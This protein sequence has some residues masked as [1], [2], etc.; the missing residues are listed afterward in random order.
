MKFFR[1]T[2]VAMLIA[3]A[4]ASTAIQPASAFYFGEDLSALES[5]HGVAIVYPKSMGPEAP[6]ASEVAAQTTTEQSAAAEQL[7]TV[8]AT[9][10]TAEVS[11]TTTTTAAPEVTTV[12][13]SPAAATTE[14]TVPVAAASAPD[15]S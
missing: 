15:A 2:H 5:Q 13:A 1:H 4:V 3:A 9:A 6:A 7:T 14:E 11:S 8:S 12:T 10:E